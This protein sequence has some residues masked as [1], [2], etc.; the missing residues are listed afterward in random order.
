MS[1]N[2]LTA[3]KTE[4]IPD[5]KETEVTKM[6]ETPVERVHLEKGCY[7]VFYVLLYFWNNDA[8]GQKG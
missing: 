3:A 4:K 5:T 8:F 1:S 6:S 7:N 2:K